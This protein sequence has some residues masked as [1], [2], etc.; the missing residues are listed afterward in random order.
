MGIQ[1]RDW[2]REEMAAKNGMRYNKRNATYSPVDKIL[3]SSIRDVEVPP[4]NR[5]RA[6]EEMRERN[7]KRWSLIILVCCSLVSLTVA[8]LLFMRGMKF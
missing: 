4:Y 3:H 8:A 1:D 6:V 5:F 2:Y 7:R